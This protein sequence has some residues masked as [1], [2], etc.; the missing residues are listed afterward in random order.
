MTGSVRAPPTVAPLMVYGQHIPTEQLLN[1]GTAR[2]PGGA[3]MITLFRSF[4][5][6]SLR[7]DVLYELLMRCDSQA[8]AQL[9]NRAP[10][11]R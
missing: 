10:A 1:A 7:V 9:A 8:N 4:I 3:V 11:G 6:C 5:M 2:P